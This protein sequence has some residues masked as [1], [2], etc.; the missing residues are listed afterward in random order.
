[1]FHF[2]QRPWLCSSSGT[3]LTMI[4]TQS[5]KTL[6]LTFV[7]VGALGTLT[8]TCCYSNSLANCLL[9]L[10]LIAGAFERGLNG[11]LANCQPSPLEI[12]LV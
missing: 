7:G 5:S 3:S 11:Q 2:T 1:M 4:I 9:S 10:W 8:L 6:D 12:N